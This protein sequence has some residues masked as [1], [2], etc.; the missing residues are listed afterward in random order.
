[1][2][3]KGNLCGLPVTIRDGLEKVFANI[4]SKMSSPDI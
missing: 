4:L 1:M 3:F 2:D